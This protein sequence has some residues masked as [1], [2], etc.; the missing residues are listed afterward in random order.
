MPGIYIHIPFCKQ[1]CHYCNFHFSTSLKYRKQ[2][3]NA[4]CDELKLRAL[5]T[6]ESVETLYF[7]GGTPSLLSKDELIQIINTVKRFYKLNP[8]AE[9]SIEVNPDDLNENYL[10]ELKSININRLSIGVQSF[11]DTELKLMNRVHSAKQ[12][13]EAISLAKHYFSNISLD[14]IYGMPDSTMESFA[15]NLQEFIDLEVPHISAYALTVEPKTALNHYV[16]NEIIHLLDEEQVEK[17][18]QWLCKQLQRFGFIHYELSNFGLPNYF[19]ENNS[20]YW[21]G[22]HYVGIGPS[23]HSYDGKQRSWNIS[24]NALYL[25]SISQNNL[26]QQVEILS[27]HDRFNERIMI[28]LRTLWGVSLDEIE[29]E[30]GVR[31]AKH[32]LDQA[33]IY[34]NQ[35]LLLVESNTLKTTQKGKFLADGIAADLF[36]INLKNES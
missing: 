1:A 7:G 8:Q 13:R 5:S 22:K 10:L 12:A 11:V 17:Q 16:E 26:P 29:H 27:I 21:K 9:I 3:V 25:D 31:Y 35:D 24:N 30:F 15:V 14:I 2:I 20:A 33:Q 23:A 32:L 6:S 34:I 28:G 36:L 19:S 18:F 4:L